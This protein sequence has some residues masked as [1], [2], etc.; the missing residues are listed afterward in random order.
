MKVTVHRLSLL[1]SVAVPP[2]PPVNFEHG[3]LR[4]FPHAGLQIGSQ[5][6]SIVGLLIGD[7]CS[8]INQNLDSSMAVCQV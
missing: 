8:D 1:V 6:S 7:T 2:V 3:S 5:V 4:G